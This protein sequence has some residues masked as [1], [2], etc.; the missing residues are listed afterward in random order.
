MRL[1]L[2]VIVA[3]LIISTIV[4]KFSCNHMRY[5]PVTDLDILNYM[6]MGFQYAAVL[7][8]ETAKANIA[9]FRIVFGQVIKVEPQLVYFRTSLKTNVA[10]VVLANSITLVPGTITV[11][12]NDGLFCVYCLNRKI[13]KDVK[14]SIFIRQL[15]KFEE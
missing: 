4:Y 5:K 14:D 1:N 3:G 11:A 2:E 6:V 9:I 15:K 7:I 10:R 8:L 12:L 13:A